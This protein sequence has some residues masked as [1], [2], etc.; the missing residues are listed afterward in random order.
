VQPAQ[1]LERLQTQALRARHRRLVVLTGDRGACLKLAA[2][3]LPEQASLPWIACP[4]VPARA[5]ITPAGARQLLGRDLAGAVYDLHAGVDPDALGIIAGAIRGGG[6]LCLVGPPLAGWPALADPQ[7]ARLAVTPYPEDAVAGRFLR[8]MAAVLQAD[9]D[10]VIA[11]PTQAPE[12]RS[13]AVLDASLDAS[14]DVP[15]ADATDPASE[16]D[17]ATADQVRAVMAVERAVQGRAHRPVVL[18]ADR[19]RGKSSAFGIAAARLLRA[20]VQRLLVTAPRAA[21]AEAV[22]ERVAEIEPSARRSR[23]RVTVRGGELRFVPPDA[24]L[25]ERW[26]ARALLVDEA[27][28]L[29]AA[30]LAALLE[31]YPRIAFATT[32]HGYE[33]TGRGFDVRFRSTLDARTPAW[34]ELRL[35]AP[36]RFAPGDP[37]ERVMFRALLLDAQPAEDA[38][39]TRRRAPVTPEIAWPHRDAL[40]AEDATLAQAFGLLVLAH[41]RTRPFDLRFLLDAPD[42]E[43]GLALHEGH[44][45]GVCLVTRE[46][47]LDAPLIEEIRAGRRR[48]QGHLGP[49]TLAS[50]LGLGAGA[51]LRSARVLR[52]AVHPALRRRRIGTRL[53]DSLARRSHEA[54]IDFLSASF[55]A[56]AEIMAFWHGA[57]YRP[58]RLGLRR[59]ASSGTHSALVL[60]PL[61]EA[62]AELLGDARR[63]HARNAPTALADAHAEIEPGLVEAILAGHAGALPAPDG[64]DVSAAHAFVRGERSAEDCIGALRRIALL[65]LADGSVAARLDASSRDL[66]VRRLAQLHGWPACVERL[67][68]SGRREA[69]AR[70]REALSALLA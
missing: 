59:E 2:E 54:G 46:G 5:P 11:D 21:A 70:L 66:I 40:A 43:V 49:E 62:G 7:R 47:G 15:G 57:G 41:Y 10:V 45:A 29:P 37:L 30:V 48:P 27:A 32:V 25:R 13:T 67:E 12:P 36:V 22:F 69:I 19:G 18:I 17:C 23:G 16:P 61:T 4:D 63:Q 65:R 64:G 52:I 1:A 39:L 55:G 44:V 51:R 58:V 24:L 3:A 8:R 20:G 60:R 56:T 28:G 14:P 9:P 53:L 38:T 68:L 35:A 50:H 34:R 42:V 33:G 26:D 31:R 6:L